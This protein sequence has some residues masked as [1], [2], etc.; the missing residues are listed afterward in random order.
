MC[1][2]LFCKLFI[3]ICFL[4]I[5]CFGGCAIV[6]DVSGDVIEFN[7][8]GDVGYVAKYVSPAVVGVGGIS[9][10]GNLSVGSGV[11]VTKNGLI[12]TNSHVV[13]GCSKINIYLSDGTEVS[14][15]LIY[16]DTVGD[17]AI[18]KSGKSLP[19][20]LVGNSEEMSVGDEIL[21]VGTP[22]SLQLTHTFTKGIVSAMDRTLSISSGSGDGYMQNLIQHDASLN[23]G[24]SGG[25][26]LNSKG[27]VI[28]I[29]TLKISGG[30]GIGFAIPSKS[31]KSL[32]GSF[33]ENINYE[34]PKIGA[35]GL[36][37]SI[38]KFNRKTE[39]AKGF[40]I[41]DL[42][43]AGVL[44]KCGVSEGSVITKINDTHIYNTLDLKNEL[45]KVKRND[46]VKFEIYKDGIY[47]NIGIKF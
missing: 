42:A 20:L 8:D 22:L 28:G 36:D 2:N 1:K 43:D 7:S 15:K 45:Y 6:S 17:L 14:A 47:K 27:E 32:L 4:F 38:A 10:G 37:S 44:K 3:V 29:N 31:F 16:E 13:N 46:V 19:Y 5:F 24:N 34:V 25:P 11:C 39:L 21:A 23:P 26:L 18:L 30:E 12:L 33:V 9:C 41:I 35:F 40:Y